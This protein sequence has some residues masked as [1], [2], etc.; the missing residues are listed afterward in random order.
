MYVLQ[1]SCDDDKSDSSIDVLSLE[2]DDLDVDDLDHDEDDLGSRD[3]RSLTS[4]QPVLPSHPY[5]ILRVS[6]SEPGMFR[7]HQCLPTSI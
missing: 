1:T 4:G 3:D 5:F 2:T 6:S 7:K